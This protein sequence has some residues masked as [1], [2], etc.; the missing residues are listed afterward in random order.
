MSKSIATLLILGTLL[1]L[2]SAGHKRPLY[3]GI[4]DAPTPTKANTLVKNNEPV[5]HSCSH[6]YV[7][8]SKEPVVGAGSCQSLCF[9]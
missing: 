5:V 9:F 1:S 7:G 6:G 8:D 2:S 4:K 3:P